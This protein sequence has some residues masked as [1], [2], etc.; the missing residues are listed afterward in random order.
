MTFWIFLSSKC[1]SA[2]PFLNQLVNM[3]INLHQQ[4]DLKELEI[5]YFHESIMSQ[6]RDT[7]AVVVLIVVAVHKG[8]S[9]VQ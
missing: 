4:I 1:L 9:L 2:I 7:I 8:F 3:S 5:N 6:D